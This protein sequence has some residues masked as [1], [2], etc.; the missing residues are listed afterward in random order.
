MRGVKHK[1]GE[2]HLSVVLK[3]E[4]RRAVRRMCVEPLLVSG[5]LLPSLLERRRLPI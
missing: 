5:C 2:H 3:N 1:K 4:P